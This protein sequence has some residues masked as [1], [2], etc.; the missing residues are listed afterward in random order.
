MNEFAENIRL[1][2]SSSRLLVH[3]GVQVCY[4]TAGPCSKRC[5]YYMNNTMN[6]NPKGYCDVDH[7]NPA[8]TVQTK[9][10]SHSHRI[11]Y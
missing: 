1:L 3:T 7:S 8:S 2:F 4:P 9:V 11:H 10:N 5:L 6:Y